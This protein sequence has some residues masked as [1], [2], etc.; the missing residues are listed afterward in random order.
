MLQEDDK[1]LR[2]VDYIL[3]NINIVWEISFNG[4]KS[5]VFHVGNPKNSHS[6]AT[7]I[8]KLLFARDFVLI[9]LE[10]FVPML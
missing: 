7:I 4:E 9:S 5:G 2:T 3:V 1:Q 10:D 6:L 8:S